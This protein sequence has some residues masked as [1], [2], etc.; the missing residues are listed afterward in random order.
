M[1]I[2]CYSWFALNARQRRE[3]F[4]STT[5]HS[6]GYESFLPFSRAKRR[7]TDR[8]K[9]IE[10]PLFPG[11]VFCRFDPRDKLSILTIPGVLSIVGNGK[12]PISI[13]DAEIQALQTVVYSG[14]LAQEWGYLEVGKRITI[15]QGPLQ[16]VQ[17]TVLNCESHKKKLLVS[18]TLLRRSIAVNIDPQWAVVATGL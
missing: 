15:E 6:K 16:G 3:K 2:S 8:V 7:W 17:G 10:I 11:Y 13:E 4:V 14:L 12:V 1:Y 5:L 9:N 18:I